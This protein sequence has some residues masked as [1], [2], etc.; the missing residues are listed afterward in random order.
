MVRKSFRS[1]AWVGPLA[2]VLVGASI[3]YFA[4]AGDKS[5]ATPTTSSSS[6][7]VTHTPTTG[8]NQQSQVSTPSFAYLEPAGWAA[9]SQEVLNSEGAASGIAETSAP[10]A[11][12]TVAVEPSASSPGTFTELKNETLSTIE[13][14]ENF[15]LSSNSQIQVGGKAAQQFIYS[16]SSGGVKIKQQLVVLISN[17][18][19][20]SLLF[21]CHESDFGAQQPIFAKILASFAFK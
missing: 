13:K 18:Q 17:G 7:Q 2:V 9:L 1:K 14:F 21:N 10:N 3:I 5:P 16:F 19:V 20:Y 15:S 6:Q 4:K 12:F 8:Q 11:K